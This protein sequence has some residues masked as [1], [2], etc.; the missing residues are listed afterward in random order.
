M[1]TFLPWLVAVLALGG[2]WFFYNSGQ[3]KSAEIIALE[4]Q[5]AELDGLRAELE[6]LKQEQVSAS[7]LERLRKNSRDALRL[8]N[9]IGQLRD[10]T[11]AIEQQAQ[12]ARVDA[13]RAQAQA[14]TAQSEM[15]A[16]SR[17]Q[18]QAQE[19]SAAR[20]L[21]Q[22][23]FAARYGLTAEGLQLAQT[24]ILQLR[25]IDG[26]KQQWALEN[27]QPATVT[28]TVEQIAPYLR[29]GTLSCPAAGSY[30]LRSVGEA[31]TCNRPGHLVVE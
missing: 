14:L 11:A 20:T 30:L 29:D 8:R 19:A 18:A 16:L 4:E 23:M 15:Q 7:E 5:V 21:E 1:K 6:T 25:H 17:Q 10:Q 13:E 26:A 28:P 2:G 27:G 31:P 9:E 24:C 12:R 22:Q 3:S